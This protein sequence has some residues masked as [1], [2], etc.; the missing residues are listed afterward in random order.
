MAKT[1]HN[2]LKKAA[3]EAI[4]AL[5][6]DS[7]VEKEETLSSLEEVIEEAEML[8]DAVREDMEDFEDDD[9]E[10]FEEEELDA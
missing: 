10:E 3:I 6:S 1:S 7:S 2:D 4:Q 5:H 9:E 8:A